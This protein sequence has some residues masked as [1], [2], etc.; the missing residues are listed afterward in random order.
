MTLTTGPAWRQ[1]S[2]ASTPA[3]AAVR[4]GSALDST[5]AAR[6]SSPPSS[7]T[8]TAA[9]SSISTR[10][11]GLSRRIRAPAAS[12]AARRAPDT[13]PMPPRA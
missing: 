8:P 6:T 5:R 12:A 4:S 3:R 10:S 2:G 7:T 9:P 13:A 1:P 11:T